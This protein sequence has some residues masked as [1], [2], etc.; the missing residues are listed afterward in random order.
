M[1]KKGVV[2]ISRSLKFEDVDDE[3]RMKSFESRV[4]KTVN[5]TPEQ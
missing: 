5:I 1:S 3:R 4:N 2:G